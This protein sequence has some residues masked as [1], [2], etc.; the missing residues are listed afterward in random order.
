MRRPLCLTNNGVVGIYLLLNW[1]SVA[2]RN[3]PR[4]LFVSSSGLENAKQLVTAYR[5]GEIK[6]MTPELWHAKKVIDSTL[7]PGTCRALA[8]GDTGTLTLRRYRQ[9]CVSAFSDVMLRYIQ[10]VRHRRNAHSR[11]S[12]TCCLTGPQATEADGNRPQGHYYGR[13]PISH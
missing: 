2:N 9:T 4:T 11:A 6:S 8:I 7:H 3:H 1:L 10:P 12:S 5:Q 13:S